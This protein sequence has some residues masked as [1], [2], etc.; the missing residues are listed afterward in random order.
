[1]VI[2]AAKD[3]I[4]NNMS[5][6]QLGTKPKHRAQE[7]LFVVQSIILLYNMCGMAVIAQLFDI[8]KFFDREM[9]RDCM[10]A[11]YNSGVRGKL[12][13]LLFELNK[14]TN[15]KVKT[16]V[17]ISEEQQTGEGVGQGSLDSAILSS[18]VYEV[19]YGEINI[20]PLLYQD[21]I[22]RLC[23]D[24]FS[25]Q[26]GNEFMDNVMETKLL[27][28]NIDKSCYIVI[29][30]KEA[31][32]KI[33]ESLKENPLKLSGKLMK[34]ADH[35]KYLGDYIS[36]LGSAETAF[37]TVT[38]RHRKAM[39]AIFEIKAV[40]ED[41]RI[42]VVGGLTTGLEIWEVAVIPYLLNNCDTWAYM[43]KNALEVLDSLQNQFLRSLLALP[44]GCPTPAL[45]WETGTPTMENRVIKQKLLLV[46]H[47][48]NLPEDSLAKQVA[49]VQDKLNLPGL[50]SE[51]KEIIK[52]LELPN[53]E[54]VSKMQ[55]KSKVNESMINKN[56]KDIIQQSERYKKICS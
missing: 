53:V 1:M 22:F 47:L 32:A 54:S 8:S 49:E 39:N 6:F 48:V 4:I 56:K 15:I 30:D 23:L 19:S 2:T 3:K 28:F 45:L 51:M 29:G 31:K 25:A 26:V 27:D 41:C 43:P 20:Q 46:H 50:I 5:K 40:I 38:K 18:E 13:R 35:E 36:G 14:E 10:D 37:I 52:H 34:E 12:Y 17:G 21:D 9:L 24:P 11:L 42:N 33:R 55:W 7:H 44:K 16:G